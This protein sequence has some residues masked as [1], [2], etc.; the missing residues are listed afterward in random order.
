MALGH[1]SGQFSAVEELAHLSHDAYSFPTDLWA[2][3]VFDFAVAYHRE[4]NGATADDLV[5]AMTGL[6]YGRTA[7]LVKTIWDMSTAQAEEVV[8][9][10]AQTFLRLKSYMVERWREYNQTI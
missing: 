1:E 10:Q 5:E 7:G 8:K 2:K 9:A 3:V 6:Y 4:A